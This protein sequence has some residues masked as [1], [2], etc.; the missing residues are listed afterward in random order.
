MPL[1]G[2]VFALNIIAT[3]SIL[4]SLHLV[5]GGA[6]GTIG[7]FEIVELLVPF[8][9][10]VT[11]LY[12]PFNKRQLIFF[13]FFYS[14]FVSILGI[15]LVLYYGGTW[16]ISS[17]YLLKGK[18]LVGPILAVSTLTMSL[19]LIKERKVLPLFVRIIGFISIGS[20][21][22]S[23][24]VLRNRSGLLALLAVISLLLFKTLFTRKRIETILVIFL[25]IIGIYVL[26]ISGNLVG[27]IQPALQ[28]VLDAFT[29]NYQIG[30]LESLSAGRWSVYMD[31]ITH[32]ANNP[33]FGDVFSLDRFSRI[34]HNYVLHK[35][36]KYGIVGSLP[37]A[38]FYLYLWLFAIKKTLWTS[39]RESS[40]ISMVPYIFLIP[41]I[42]S[43]LEY[44]HPYGPGVS[45]IMVWF[46]L[47][48]YLRNGQNEKRELV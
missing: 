33:F 12:I 32:L 40:F 37:M 47:G 7:Y 35:W 22:A 6:E 9:I 38:L 34:P 5:N 46:L 13:V 11:S 18:N 44:T 24:V 31:S 41:L 10:L 14:L 39:N 19:I 28:P 3:F 17:Q 2:R 4:L 23:L 42:T 16:A 15:S 27:I 36:V 30:D 1:L 21:F 25:A 43:M 48:Q 29:L 26:A 45:Q 8:G 20:L